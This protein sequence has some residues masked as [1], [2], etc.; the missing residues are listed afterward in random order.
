MRAKKRRTD[1]PLKPGRY[2]MQGNE[3]C[4]EGAIAAGCRF[5]AGYPIT[6][7]SEIMEH[8]AKRFK[9]AGGVFIQME[10]EIASISAVIGASWTGTKAMT[11]TSGP[12]FSLMMESVGY[13][14]MTETPCVV[15][16][17]QRAGPSTGQATRVASGD[18]LQARFGSH[19][20]YEIIALSPQSVQ[21][22]YDMTIRAFNL[23]E[24][25]RV[26]TF[27]LADEAVAHLREDIDIPS[28]IVV[29]DRYSGDGGGWFGAEDPFGVPPMPS[30]GEGKKILV[31]GSTHDSMGVR[32]TQDREVHQRLVTRLCDKIRRNRSKMAEFECCDLDDAEI[33]LICYGFVARSTLCAIK[34]CRKLGIKAGMIRLK[35]IWPFS[36][37]R[38]KRLIK[39]AKII[40]VPEMNMGQICREIE[41]ISDVDVLP[42]CQVDGN[43]IE[44]ESIIEFLRSL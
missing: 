16:D 36:D 10:D 17:I 28:E 37:E 40:V 12:G 20:D 30:F 24:I 15:V 39:T 44:P 35:T 5:F 33:I 32:R 19:G 25:Y 43:V 8:V 11:A 42:F 27:I 29:Y 23:S 14:C 7:Q 26:V 2:M 13:A 9:D 22:M 38:I 18:M 3:A 31:T 34:Y 21:E 41:R 4:A 6:P 1:T